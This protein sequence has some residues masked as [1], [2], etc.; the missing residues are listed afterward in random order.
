MSP[1]LLQFGRSS[2][3]AQEKRVVFNIIEH[4]AAGDARATAAGAATLVVSSALA[5]TALAAGGSIAIRP[6]S[7]HFA[8]ADLDEIYPAPRNWTEKAYPKLIYYNRLPKGG[9]FAAWEQ[10]QEFTSELRAAFRSL[11]TS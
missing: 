8:D 9:H 10:P 5:E 7:V 6:F 1:T 4:V 3:R 2:T 11:H